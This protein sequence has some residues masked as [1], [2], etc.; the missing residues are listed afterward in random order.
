MKKAMNNRVR[1]ALMICLLLA[2]CAASIS[3]TIA[4]L[5]DETTPVTNTFT[6][7]DV[8]IELAETTGDSYKMVPGQAITKD[9]TVTVEASSEAC[10]VFVKIE[11][12]NS[13]ED[14]M[15]YSVDGAW[16]ALDAANHPGVYYM[17]A[18]DMPT[19]QVFRVLSGD[20]VMVKTTV[21]KDMM[22]DLTAPNYPTLTFTAYAIQKDGFADANA[23]WLKLNPSS[24][25]P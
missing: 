18:A 17:V 8:D 12:A 2:V 20:K 10:W 11:E 21:T 22:D 1:I 14:F 7:S 19:D 24:A 3:G 6:R 23:A 9:P 15:S 4:W 25:T 5:A 13:F 16:A